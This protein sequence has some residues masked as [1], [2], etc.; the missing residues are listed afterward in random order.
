MI[1]SNK[2]IGFYLGVF[3]VLSILPS[4]IPVCD[5]GTI[6]VF[7]NC[8]KDT[9][10]IGVSQ[11]GNIDSVNCQLY[12]HYRGLNKCD[13]DTAGISLWKERRN[14]YDKHLV[15]REF[16]KDHYIYPDSICTIN[17][18]YLFEN[19]DTCY[20]FLVK[21]RDAKQYSWDEIRAKKLYRRW[22]TVKNKD[23]EFDK[24]I[25]YD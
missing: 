17:V 13:L 23:G 25:K 9:L 4:C 5:W 20:F 6:I 24:D 7:K 12:P 18:S 1:A 2:K 8:T 11:Y 19:N 16:S 3:L 10:F 22:V 21:W 15:Y 14:P